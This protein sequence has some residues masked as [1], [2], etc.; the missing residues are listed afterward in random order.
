MEIEIKTVTLDG[1]K[2][3]YF[4]SKHNF[5][6]T[7]RARNLSLAHGR[8]TVSA[9]PPGACVK[10]LRRSTRPATTCRMDRTPGPCDTPG[11]RPTQ[12]TERT[13]QMRA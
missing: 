4:Y 8:S 11:P 12:P 10:H 9:T 13:T 7:H 5:V 3:A 1:K 6:F 2:L